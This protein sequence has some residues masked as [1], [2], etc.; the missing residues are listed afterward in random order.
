MAFLTIFAAIGF[1]ATAINCAVKCKVDRWYG[2][3]ALAAGAC[4]YLSFMSISGLNDQERKLE[5]LAAYPNLTIVRVWKSG[6]KVSYYP[7]SQQYIRCT[8]NVMTVEGE[9]TYIQYTAGRLPGCRQ[10][11]E[12]LSE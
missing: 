6:N 9:E 2:L 10:S 7:D 1:A 8:G 5:L 12:N 4:C 3:P 11:V